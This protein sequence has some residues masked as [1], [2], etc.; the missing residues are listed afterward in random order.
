V[1]ATIELFQAEH[2]TQAEWAG[3]FAARMVGYEGEML[4]IG[5]KYAEG[6]LGLTVRVDGVIVACMGVVRLWPG[7]GEVWCFVT[8]EARKHRKTLCSAA[9]WGVERGIEQLGLHRVQAHV[10]MDFPAGLRWIKYLGFSPEG[11][12]PE[13]TADRVDVSRWGRLA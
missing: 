1:S 12:C 10:R 4:H 2:L 11:S 7:V 13:Y 3:E 9:L 8:A 5:Q 6:G